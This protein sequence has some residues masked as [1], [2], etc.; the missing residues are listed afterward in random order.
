MGEDAVQ[1]KEVARVR[2]SW[3]KSALKYLFRM[4]R[5]AAQVE[6]NRNVSAR[7]CAGDILFASLFNVHVCGL[8]SSEVYHVATKVAALRA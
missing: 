6:N 4:T 7:R 3:A 1:E 8:A 5:A 2:E